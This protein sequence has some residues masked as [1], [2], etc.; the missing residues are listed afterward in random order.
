MCCCWTAELFPSSTNIDDHYVHAGF[1]FPDD[2]KLLVYLTNVQFMIREDEA[3]SVVTIR[4]LI[5]L[6]AKNPELQ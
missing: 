2:Y 4:R 3:A 1:N 6:N 5:S